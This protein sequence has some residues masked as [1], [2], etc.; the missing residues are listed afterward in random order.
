MEHEGGVA[1]ICNWHAYD[2]HQRA[3]TGTGGFWNKSTSGK[4]L[5]Y[6]IIQIS[7]NTKKRPILENETLKILW[8]FEIET[9][10]LILARQPDFIII[11][12]KRELAE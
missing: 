6:N 10:H 9:D 5:K 3:N 11:S 2:G 8:D 1:T 4:H 12:K 7:Q